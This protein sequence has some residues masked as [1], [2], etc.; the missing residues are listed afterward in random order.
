MRSL[1]FLAIRIPIYKISLE[2]ARSEAIF[3]GSQWSIPLFRADFLCF[4][5]KIVEHSRYLP[6]TAGRVTIRLFGIP[7]GVAISLGLATA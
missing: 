1:A 6:E 4:T 5:L 2:E 3:L 7:E